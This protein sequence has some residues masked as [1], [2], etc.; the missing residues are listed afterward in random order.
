MDTWSCG[1]LPKR[2]ALELMRGMWG[3][4]CV[5]GIRKFRKARRDACPSSMTSE[6]VTTAED[7]MAVVAAGC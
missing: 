4:V 1:L 2:P 3:V 7:R 6:S 5:C